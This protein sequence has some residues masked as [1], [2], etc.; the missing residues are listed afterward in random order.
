MIKILDMNK[1]AEE[2]TAPISLHRTSDISVKERIKMY[3]DR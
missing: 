3:S 2:L 1:S